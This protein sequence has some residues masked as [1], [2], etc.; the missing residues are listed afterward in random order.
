MFSL[1]KLKSLIYEIGYFPFL[2][3]TDLLLLSRHF[4][5]NLSSRCHHP[6][7][8]PLL[9]PL[10]VATSSIFAITPSDRRRCFRQSSPS[11]SHRRIRWSRSSTVRCCPSSSSKPLLIF[12]SSAG[13]ITADFAA[14]SEQ[15]QIETLSW[16]VQ[17]DLCEQRIYAGKL[18]ENEK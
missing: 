1:L 5:K 18:I 14:G 17:R 2:N 4:N 3:H 11:P 13:P 6:L 10:V 15:K 9:R 7:S 16:C 8:P 12:A